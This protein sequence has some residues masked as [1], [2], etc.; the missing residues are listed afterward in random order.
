MFS[1]DLWTCKVVELMGEKVV[2]C[3]VSW[4][5]YDMKSFTHQAP[6]TYVPDSLRHFAT[7]GAFTFC[8]W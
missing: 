6:E 5:A 3:V 7:L 8:F 4:V 2:S 1:V